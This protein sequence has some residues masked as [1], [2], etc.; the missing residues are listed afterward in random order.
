MH[1]GAFERIGGFAVSTSSSRPDAPAS[2]DAWLGR[3]ETLADHIT[4]FPLD[5]LAATLDRAA[6]GEVVPPLW[7]WLYFVP[8]APTAELGPDGH[9]RRGGF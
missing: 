1:I 6:P 7:H 4:V 2:L 9:P 3:T 5:A 8:V